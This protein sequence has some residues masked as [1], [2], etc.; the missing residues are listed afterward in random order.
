MTIQFHAPVDLPTLDKEKSVYFGQKTV[1]FISYLATDL[2]QRTTEAS[3]GNRSP[4]VQLLYY[5]I[6]NH[7]CF[8]RYQSMLFI[9]YCSL[10]DAAGSSDYRSVGFNGKKTGKNEL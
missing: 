8:K 5:K 6:L 9:T 2:V 10:S 1:Q 3:L 4:A 7:V